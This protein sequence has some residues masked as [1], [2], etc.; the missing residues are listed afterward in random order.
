LKA[1]LGLFLQA[2]AVKT[3]QWPKLVFDFLG[4]RLAKLQMQSF[5]LLLEWLACTWQLRIQYNCFHS[6]RLCFYEHWTHLSN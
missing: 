6:N 3:I 4:Q 5:Y 2:G 1:R